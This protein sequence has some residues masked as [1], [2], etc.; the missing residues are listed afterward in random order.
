MSGC[1]RSNRRRFLKQSAAIA[2]AVP[3]VWTVRAQDSPKSKNDRPR[4]GAI[5]LRYQGSVIA[6]QAAAYGDLVALCDVDGTILAKAREE[7]GGKAGV[8]SDYRKLLE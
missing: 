6:R 3:Y 1:H 7:F 5:G 4:I 8:Y 2:V